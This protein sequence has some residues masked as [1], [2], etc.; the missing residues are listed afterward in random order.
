MRTT[1][2]EETYQAIESTRAILGEK[3]KEYWLKVLKPEVITAYLIWTG[4]EKA[5]EPTTKEE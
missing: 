2:G 5:E 1:M 3:W 4:E